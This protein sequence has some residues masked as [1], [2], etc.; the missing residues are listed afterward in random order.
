MVRSY[1][2]V[3]SLTD[4]NLVKPIQSPSRLHHLLWYFSVK[5]AQAAVYAHSSTRQFPNTAVYVEGL[6]PDDGADVNEQVVA[7]W[8]FERGLT[9]HLTILLQGIV[10]KSLTLAVSETCERHS[11]ASQPQCSLGLQPGTSPSTHTQSLTPTN[12]LSSSSPLVFL[13]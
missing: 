4:S 8:N 11:A 6:S 10:G 2:S 12:R 3:F 13:T 1:Q 5:A 9:P 7:F